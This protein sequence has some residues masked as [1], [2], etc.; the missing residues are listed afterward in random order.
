MGDPLSENIQMGPL[1]RLDLREY[2]HLQV[3]D[4]I[5]QGAEALLGCKPISGRAHSTHPQYSTE[6]R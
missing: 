4:S 2:L 5:A 1:A 6:S 3:C